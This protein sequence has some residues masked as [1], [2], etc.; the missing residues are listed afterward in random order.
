MFGAEH[1]PKSRSIRNTRQFFREI[2][3]LREVA[4]APVRDGTIDRLNEP[5]SAWL[6][7]VISPL[8]SIS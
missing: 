3:P 2:K 5:G 6:G 1:S 4:R 8:I 7:L